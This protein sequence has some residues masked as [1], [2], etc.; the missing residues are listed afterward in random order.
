M[1]SGNIYKASYTAS[2]GI[3]LLLEDNVMATPV[4]SLAAITG[5]KMFYY[6]STA[7]IVYYWASDGANPSTHT[8]E[9]GARYDVVSCDDRSNITFNGLQ[10]DGAGGQYGRGF[11]LKPTWNTPSNITLQNMKITNNYYTGVWMSYA[12][13]FTPISNFKIYSS[14]IDHNGVFGLRIEGQ[15]SSYRSTGFRLDGSHV[16]NNGLDHT[17]IG[18]IGVWLN[19][20]S[21]PIIT[22]STLND[23]QGFLDWS[24]N[25]YTGDTINALVEKNTFYNGYKSNAHFDVN[26]NGFIFRYN[27][28]YGAG[29]NGVWVEEHLRANGVSYI[30]NNTSYGNMHGFVFGPGSTI[31]TVSGV[32][33]R[34]NVFAYNTRASDDLNN[35]ASDN[36]VDYNIYYTDGSAQGQF[37][38]NNAFVDFATWK[39]DTGWDSHSTFVEPSFLNRSSSDFHLTSSSPAINAGT[40]LSL[41][42]D[43]AGTIVPQG[44]APDDGVYEFILP[45]APSALAQYKTD[46][47]TAISSGAYTNEGTIILKFNMSSSNSSDSLTPQIE[48]QPNGTAFTNSVTNTGSAVAFTGTAVTGSV[49]VTGLTSGT[50]YHWQARINNSAGNGSWVSM[51][52]SPDFRVDTTAPT[53][54]SLSSP[55]GFSKEDTKPT[56]VFKKSSDSG[57]G[58]SS[59]SVSLDSGKNRSLSTSGIP[60]SGNGS[61]DY[62]WKDDNSVKIEFINENDSDSSNDEIHVYFKDLNNTELTEG[63]HTWTVTTYDA[64]SNST[65]QSADFYIDKTSPAISELAVANVSIV[66]SGG[67]YNIS[68]LNRTPSFSGLAVD[69]Y[70]G[71]IKTNSNNSTDTFDKVSSG[72]QTLTLTLKRQKDD[73]TYADYLTQDYSLSNI[74]DSSNDKKSSR[75]Y[76]TVPFPLIDGHYQ[77]TIALKDSAGNTYTQPVFYLSINNNLPAPLQ[78]LFNGNLETKITEQKTVP[79]QTEEEK[80]AVKQNG[81]TVKIKV[82][83]TTNRP[84]PGAKVTIHSKVQETTTDKNGIAQFSN[85]ESGQHK[86]NIAYANYQGE[87]TVNLTGDVKEFDLNIQVKQTNAFLN[88]QVISVIGIMAFIILI[89]VVLLIKAKKKV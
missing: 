8:M 47:T 53:A 5:A 36:D 15:S 3:Y 71:S 44:S 56:L 73:K 67:I 49:T 31:T 35:T 19:H 78:S 86:I 57:S 82:V 51:G 27:I 87:Q 46:G 43:F 63:K 20:L 48:I 70:Q 69:S 2:I 76:I 68:I 7:H 41:T 17:S 65:S 24:D 33:I 83:D 14:D 32:V 23:N 1:Q 45:S 50:S 60:T 55:T 89:T 80:Q 13:N 40:D 64:Q 4:G 29:W 77:S 22:G 81:Y 12:T 37:R 52:G 59:Y 28:T 34:N 72:P 25:L 58:L 79:A 9:I 18:Q 66:N 39:T 21:A 62:V 16:Y 74:Q 85:V 11:G 42:S 88:P 38:Y 54:G 10:I 75:F 61:A 6:D 26:S 84:V 30:Y